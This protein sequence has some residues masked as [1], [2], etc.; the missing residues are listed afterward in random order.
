[1]PPID[2]LFEA[3]WGEDGGRDV[4]YLRGRAR[5]IAAGTHAAI[6]RCTMHFNQ[7][8]A[9]SLM[10]CWMPWGYCPF[11]WVTTLLRGR[12]LRK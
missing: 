8:D 11:M 1:M 12:L 2:A 7:S 3:E 6:V 10:R 5:F 9:V 4:T